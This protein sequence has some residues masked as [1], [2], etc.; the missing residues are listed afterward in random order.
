[1]FIYSIIYTS[2]KSSKRGLIAIHTT[3]YYVAIREY[4]FF[5]KYSVMWEKL[6]IKL[7]NQDTKQYIKPI[8]WKWKKM[9]MNFFNFNVINSN[10]HRKRLEEIFG[11]LFIH[12][13]FFQFFYNEHELL[14]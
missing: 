14:L 6:M 4:H 11:F 5:E 10:L 3:Q 9:L 1:M 13:Y 12:C 7:K 8:L 2:K